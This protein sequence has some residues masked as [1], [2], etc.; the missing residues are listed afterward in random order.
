MK[1]RAKP[2]STSST[3]TRK[4][5]L[6]RVGGVSAKVYANAVK[7]KGRTYDSFLVTFPDPV[8]GRQGTKRFGALA[9]AKEFAEE[10]CRLV[11]N[12]QASA[13]GLTNQDASRYGEAVELLRPLNI[14]VHVA[15][16][17]YVEAARLLPAGTSL[18]DAVRFFAERHPANAPRK[19][20]GEVVAEYIA[21]RQA[22]GCS[23][24]HLR[25]LRIRLGRFGSVFQMPLASVTPS[26]VRDYLRD[27]TNSVTGGSSSNRSRANH[28]ALIIALFNYARL[29]RYVSRELAD[30]ISDLPVPKF[31]SGAVEVFAPD[32]FR[33]LLVAAPDDLVPAIAL[34]GLAGLRIA[35]ISRLDWRDVRLAERVIVVGDA[36]AKTASRRVVPICDS[37]AAW[38]A[39]HAQPF[40]QVSPTESEERGVGEALIN[41]MARLTERA[42]VAWKRNALRHSYG[43]CRL[44]ITSDVAKVSL[45]MGNSVTIVH[46]HYKSL[47]S[48]AEGRAWFA[49]APDV[50]DGK[51]VPLPK[52][53]RQ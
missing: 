19:L 36:I 29:A 46:Q 16:R 22:A 6:V 32:E 13:A 53:A 38:L 40:G 30:E 43:S 39:P 17:T 52:A 51:V 44:A 47:V 33:R 8:T 9:D 21:D 23:T 25:D 27:L 48:E 26:L 45:E 42:K 31:R 28:R 20:V 3:A 50:A 2:A 49:V 4:P 5:V 24:I 10:R 7:T 14:E 12:G 41:R 18:L 15:A 1:H 11:A 37:L 34:A 35:E